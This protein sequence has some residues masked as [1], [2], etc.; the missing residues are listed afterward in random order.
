MFILV[1]Y[2][3]LIFEY[4][5]SE[6]LLVGIE[7]YIGFF[8][9]VCMLIW[10]CLLFCVRYLWIVVMVEVRYVVGVVGMDVYL[11]FYVVWFVGEVYIGVFRDVKLMLFW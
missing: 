5:V 3:K 4:K 10:V 8:Y 1:W 7:C 2:F 11:V 9:D 6:R